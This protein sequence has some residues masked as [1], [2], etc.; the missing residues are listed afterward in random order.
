MHNVIDIEKVTLKHGKMII[1]SLEVELE[2]TVT[3]KGE[4]GLSFYVI[5]GYVEKS[6][7]NRNKKINFHQPI[8]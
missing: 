8:F 1:R 2:T 6:T 3:S 4:G 7:Q 5:H